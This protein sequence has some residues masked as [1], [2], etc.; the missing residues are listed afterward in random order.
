MTHAVNPVVFADQ[1]LVLQSP[2]DLAPTHARVEELLASD[3]SFLSTRELIEKRVDL[4]THT[5][6]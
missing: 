3:Q 1:E 6:L 2:L 4:S 5:V